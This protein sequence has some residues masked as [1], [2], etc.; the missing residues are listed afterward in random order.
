M[1]ER[2]SVCEILNVGINPANL[3]ITPNGKY[4]Y[5]ANSN[6]YSI[7]GSDSVTVLDLQKGVPK[8]TIHDSSFVEPYRIAIDNSGDYAYVCNSGSPTSAELTGTVSI[9]DIHTNTV[10]GVITG[11]DGPGAIALSKNR[12]Y[13]TNYGINGNG[14]SVSVVNLDTRQI[15][16]TIIVDQAPAALTLCPCHNYLYVINYVDGNEGNGTLNVISTKT[17]SVIK[18]I[19]G[20]FGPFGIALTK[21]GKYAY[22]TNFGSNNFAP[23]GTT[24][25]VVDLKDYRIVKNIEVGIQPS[26]I[27]ISSKFVY[28]SNYNTLYAKANFQN[29]TPGEGTIN[30]ICLKNNKVIAPTISVGQSP[31]TLTLAPNGKKL[32][33][34]KY[35]Q[36]TIG[37]ICLE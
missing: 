14:K 4:A 29:L 27:A 1:L 17:N 7:P 31:S 32:Y 11:F 9:I 35:I 37:V 20:F 18:T 25:S 22:V 3:A 5:V 30:I 8:M 6:N 24:V 16:D 2:N 26:G 19:K 36:N 34:C 13:V 12:A 23:Y 28:V 21:D 33:V 15:I 10:I